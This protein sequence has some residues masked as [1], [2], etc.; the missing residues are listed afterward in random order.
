MSIIFPKWTYLKHDNTEAIRSNYFYIHYHSQISMSS[1]STHQWMIKLSQI[2]FKVYFKFAASKLYW[3]KMIGKWMI[4][5]IQAIIH[6]VT[7]LAKAALQ[8]AFPHS[9]IVGQLIRKADDW[10]WKH[11]QSKNMN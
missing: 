7:L 8:N 1:F 9:T 11:F 4:F 2:A 5:S 10:K 6:N 3:N